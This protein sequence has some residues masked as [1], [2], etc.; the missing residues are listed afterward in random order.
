MTIVLREFEY[1]THRLLGFYQE[2][3]DSS[4]TIVEFGQCGHF[5]AHCPNENSKFLCCRCAKA[6]TYCRVCR[7]DNVLL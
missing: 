1:L 7:P 5:C 3:E 4:Y 6:F 2:Q